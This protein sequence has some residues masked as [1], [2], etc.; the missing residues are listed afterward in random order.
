MPHRWEGQCYALGN[1]VEGMINKISVGDKFWWE[2]VD[3]GDLNQHA[4]PEIDGIESV[5]GGIG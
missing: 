3:C 2:V 1:S 5:H 4:E